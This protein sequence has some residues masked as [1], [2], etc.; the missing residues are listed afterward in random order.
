MNIVKIAYQKGYMVDNNGGLVS[1]T[2]QVKL[3]LS[4]GYFYFSIR[5]DKSTRNV[6]VHRLQAY[7]K[8]GEKLFDDCIEVRH[9]NGIRTDNSWDNIAIGTHSENMMD[10]PEHIRLANAIYASSFMKKH[11]HKDIIQWY[12]NNGKSYKKTMQKFNIS[13]KGTLHFILN[14]S[15][16]ID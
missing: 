3:K 15:M 4:S 13:S 6:A 10:I 12:I 1:K 7:Q 9:L 8:Y 16:A 11:N 2:K 14:K 5:I